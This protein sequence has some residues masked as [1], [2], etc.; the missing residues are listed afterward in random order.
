MEIADDS[1]DN[2]R[3]LAQWMNEGRRQHRI[4]WNE[5]A[6]RARMT[7][8]NLRRIRRGKISVSEDAADGIEDALAWPRGSVH[9]AIRLGERPSTLPPGDA[10]HDPPRSSPARA[11]ANDDVVLSPE[12]EAL[13]L[14]AVPAFQE[15]FQIN[16][17]RRQFRYM[18]DQY[19]MERRMRALTRDDGE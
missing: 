6:K 5:V 10:E 17:T 11:T 18:R 19:I 13:Y 4:N 1:A 3:L 16:I 2:R 7:P 14:D 9:R 8:E 12:E 15:R